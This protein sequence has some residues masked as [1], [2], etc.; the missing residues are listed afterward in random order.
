MVLSVYQAFV[1]RLKC[2]TDWRNFFAGL[3]SESDI[4]QLQLQQS[5]TTYSERTTASSSSA[6][7]NVVTRNISVAAHW[8]PIASDNITG[9]AAGGKG[10]RR[11]PSV[12][13][14]Q[15]LPSSLTSHCLYSSRSL[16]AIQTP[17]L[18]PCTLEFLPVSY[19]H[20]TL[21]TIY[22]V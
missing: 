2:S 6:P 7:H 4:I 18:A 10:G 12:C 9:H 15:Y 16:Y 20:L 22:S 21:P 13:Q 1:I 5:T 8:S 14:S 19:T 17:R 11:R 3:Q